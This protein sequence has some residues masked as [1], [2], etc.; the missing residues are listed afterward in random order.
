[1]TYY[2]NK[3]IPKRLNQAYEVIS[4]SL[5]DS[6][7]SDVLARYGYVAERLDEG[8]QLYDTASDRETDQK[9]QLGA[10]VAATA[11]LVNATRA[12]R[13][14]LRSDRDFTRFVL[15]NA[16]PVLEELRLNL[17]LERSSEAV[18]R[19]G[20]HFYREVQKHPQVLEALEREYN[21]LQDVFLSRQEEL[22]ALIELMRIQQYEMGQAKVAASKRR[23]AMKALD[24]W[25]TVFIGVA[26]QAFKNDPRQLSKLGITIMTP[27]QRRERSG[28]N[29]GAETPEAPPVDA[30]VD[31]PADAPVEEPP[32]PAEILA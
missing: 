19:Q 22:E 20:T 12:F 29:G 14:K 3:S 1:M 6:E 28:E 32:A 8:M 9:A 25:M 15:E 17:V 16:P 2:S 4:I 24:D 30:P 5:S 7:I 31:P 23:R 13:L 21:L 10:Q 26:R 27:G 11:Q 18:I